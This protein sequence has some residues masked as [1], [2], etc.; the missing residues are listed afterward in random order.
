M[1]SGSHGRRGEAGFLP[2]CAERVKGKGWAGWL[3]QTS[4]WATFFKIPKSFFTLCSLNILSPVLIASCSCFMSALS[5]LISPRPLKPVYLE[6]SFS[7][8]F[9]CFSKVL[10]VSISSLLGFSQRPG[11]SGFSLIFQ[12]DVKG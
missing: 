6:V 11:S 5:R 7:P 10:S 8:H 9:T 3:A 12:V 2:G 4:G 1:D